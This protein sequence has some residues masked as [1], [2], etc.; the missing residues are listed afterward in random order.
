MQTGKCPEPDGL[1]AEFSKTFADTMSPLLLNMFNESLQSGS[2]PLMLHQAT[3]SLILK[4]DKA[5][6]PV[7]IIALSLCFVQM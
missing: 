2:L 5:Y 1:P 3:I 6:C 7:L 4:K